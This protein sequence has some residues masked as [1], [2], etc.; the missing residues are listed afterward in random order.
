MFVVVVIIVM[1]ML[2]F[3]NILVCWRVFVNF[4]IIDLFFVNFVYLVMLWFMYFNSVFYFIIFGLMSIE[5]CK[6]VKS[7]FRFF[8]WK[9]LVLSWI[10]VL[11][12]KK[13]KEE[14]IIMIVLVF[15]FV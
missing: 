13:K 9:F 8:V 14:F 12:F 2:F 4:K 3:F 1:V 6:V 7:F 11:S 15:G 10:V 5:Y